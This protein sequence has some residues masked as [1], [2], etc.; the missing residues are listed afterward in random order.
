LRP[1]AL[2]AVAIVVACGS[3]VAE[4]PTATPTATGAAATR[5]PAASPSASP[6]PPASPARTVAFPDL[7]VIAGTSEGDVYTKLV[8]GKPSGAKV[9]V[10]D[11][12]IVRI[13]HGPVALV[14]CIQGSVFAVYTYD[15]RTGAVARVPGIDG[16]AIWTDGYDGMLY[17]SRGACAPGATDCATKLVRRNV[18][19]G[20]TV[21]ID[22]RLGVV[23]DFRTTQEG[24]TIW[25]AKNSVTF[26]RPDAEAGTYLLRDTTLTKFSPHRLVAGDHGRWLL[27]SEETQSYNSGC[28]TYVVRLMQTETRLTPASVDNERAIAMLDDGRIVAFR[29]DPDG[30][31]GTM[32]I[33][34]ATSGQVERMDRGAFTPFQTAW[35]ASTAGTSDWILGF[36]YAGAPSVTLRAYRL[37]DGAFASAPGGTITAVTWLPSK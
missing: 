11:G 27:E 33:Y 16:P 18:K 2:L 34:R 30:P 36:E 13:E 19:T 8:G 28:C 5:S 9:H 1:L 4:V 24:P 22:E 26:V 21:T 17:V 12:Y 37:S 6:P 32:V 25:R 3:R 29:P 23:T 7:A 35:V 15:P 14:S 10:C 31:L 20:A